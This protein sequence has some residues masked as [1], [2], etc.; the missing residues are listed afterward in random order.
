MV[1]GKQ[2]QSNDANRILLD[3]LN[4]FQYIVSGDDDPYKEIKQ[5]NVVAKKTVPREWACPE[6]RN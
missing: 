2:L 5:A 6:E 3:S 1:L 4:G